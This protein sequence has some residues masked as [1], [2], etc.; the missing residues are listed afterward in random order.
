MITSKRHHYL[1]QFYLKGFAN[2]TN[3]FFVFDKKTEQIRKSTP[4]N[5]FFENHRNTGTMKDS[6]S[7]L[8]EEMYAHFDG[9][10]AP[11]LEL[12]RKA[13]ID[14]INLDSKTVLRLQLLIAL[15]HWRIPESDE[16]LER[17][18]DK[19]SFQE[20]GF[21]I[22][23][24]DTG[25][26]VATG[27]LQEQLKNIDLFRKMYRLFLPIM[28]QK[29]LN[30]TGLEDWGIYFRGNNLQLTCDNPIIA[31]NETNNLKGV[32]G[33]IVFHVSSDRILIHAEQAKPKNLPS[34]FILELDMLLIQQSTRFVC[35][36]E[37]KYLEYLINNLY[38]HSKSYDFREKMRDRIFSYFK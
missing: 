25:E 24:K 6:R 30:K 13:T 14:T 5:S 16:E 28:L 3:E 35:C 12:V 34:Q 7:S 19:L 36:S 1:P 27:E 37:Q 17:M 10:I 22:V 29:E 11:Y 32:K 38:S 4:L 8:L 18:I 2:N 15:L 21:N 9:E 31:K 33:N 26:S 20:T 23:N